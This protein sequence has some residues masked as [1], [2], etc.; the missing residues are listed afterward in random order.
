MQRSVASSFFVLPPGGGGAR[1]A[2][3]S[4]QKLNFLTR[5]TMH[6]KNG[7]SATRVTTNLAKTNGPTTRTQTQHR[8]TDLQM[9]LLSFCHHPE[10]KLGLLEEQAGYQAQGRQ[11]STG[12]LGFHR[13]VAV[14]TSSP[15]SLFRTRARKSRKSDLSAKCA[16][17]CAEPLATPPT[18]RPVT[19]AAAVAAAAACRV[20]AEEAGNGR[21]SR[22]ARCKWFSGRVLEP[23]LQL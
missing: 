11:A 6:M 14:T 20:C 2:S 5:G 12:Q 22:K 3:P 13:Y 1:D 7:R 8:N 23:F 21:D 18:V 16:N 9:L 15:R 10:K 4:F 17:K 19:C